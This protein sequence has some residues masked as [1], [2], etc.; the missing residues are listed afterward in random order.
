MEL[1]LNFLA[2]ISVSGFIIEIDRQEAVPC[3]H[4]T[5]AC[6]LGS[7]SEGGVGILARTELLHKVDLEESHGP[8]PE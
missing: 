5:A 4:D 6:H 2:V 8:R 7:R 3:V 1:T